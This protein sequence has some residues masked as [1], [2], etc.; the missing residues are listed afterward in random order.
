MK[1][2][3]ESKGILEKEQALADGYGISWHN[4]E[5]FVNYHY[6]YYIPVVIL[7]NLNQ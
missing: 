5:E 6:D 7:Q 4:I 3:N 1:L 2:F